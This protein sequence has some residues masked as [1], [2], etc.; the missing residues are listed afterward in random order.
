MFADNLILITKVSRKSSRICLFCLD[1]Y[2]E[3]IGQ[4]TNHSKSA[5][6]L[7]SQ[8]NKSLVILI[9]RFLNIWLD[10][11]LF[12]YLDVPI[13]PKKLSVSNCR[14]LLDKVAIA[15]NS[16]NHSTLSLAGKVVMI[17]SSILPTLTYFV[18]IYFIP[19]TTIKDISKLVRKFRWV[20]SSSNRG[21]HSIGWSLVTQNKSEGVSALKISSL[22]NTLSCLKIF[23]SILNGSDKLWVEIFNLKY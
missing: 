1:L 21:F 16:W 5:L 10:K 2:K 3:I 19:D 22:L 9:S 13:P 20:A 18:S 7:P 15:V 8:C 14:S 11:F 12:L 17:S 4:K 23:F 6:Y